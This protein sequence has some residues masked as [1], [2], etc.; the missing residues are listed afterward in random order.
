MVPGTRL[1]ANSEVPK[2][3]LTIANQFKKLNY[4]NFT[5]NTIKI[6]KRS[7][8]VPNTSRI[9][10]KSDKADDVSL[11]A[12]K[13]SRVVS[14]SVEDPNKAAAAVASDYMG[15]TQ[16]A[17]R[18]EPT[19][20]HNEDPLPDTIMEWFNIKQ[21]GRPQR[22]DDAMRV[23]DEKLSAIMRRRGTDE[24]L[25]GGGEFNRLYLRTLA[26]AIKNEEESLNYRKELLK[27]MEDDGSRR[28]RGGSPARRLLNFN[29][30][31]QRK[32]TTLLPLDRIRGGS[33]KPATAAYNSA[34]GGP[35]A[36]GRFNRRNLSTSGGVPF[37]PPTV[38]QMQDVLQR[39]LMTNNQ[40][41]F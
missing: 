26:H 21:Y 8:P 14:E 28:S 2:E 10:D 7:K 15:E 11:V 41:V 27:T 9:G 17:S 32:G 6:R 39:S 31:V 19:K 3:A 29:P 12:R 40:S 13:A 30:T 24:D 36:S 4:S 33:V 18:A 35:R 5:P 37:N 34:R 38:A 20:K 16:L 22:N 25:L 23:K 1:L